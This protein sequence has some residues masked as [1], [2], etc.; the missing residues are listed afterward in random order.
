MCWESLP[1]SA[2]ALPLSVGACIL[3]RGNNYLASF[4]PLIEVGAEYGAA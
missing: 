1:G 4:A 2:C 3:Q